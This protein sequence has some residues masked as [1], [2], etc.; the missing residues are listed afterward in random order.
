MA[1]DRAIPTSQD[2]RRSVADLAAEDAG[3]LSTELLG[4]F[5]EVLTSA[6]SE[7]RTLSRRQL[8]TLRTHG[9]TAARQGV[10][11]RALRALYLSSAWRVWRELP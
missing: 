4:D 10:A 6:V 7:G 11:L 2:R 9:D 1:H 5:L 8:R 3:G